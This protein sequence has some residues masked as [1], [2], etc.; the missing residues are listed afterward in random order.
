MMWCAENNLALST[1]KVKEIVLDFRRNAYPQPHS[2]NPGETAPEPSAQDLTCCLC[3]WFLVICNWW[4]IL[5][6]LMFF[7][8]LFKGGES[9]PRFHCTLFITTIELYLSLSGH[10]QVVP[11]PHM[12]LVLPKVF[13]G[14]CQATTDNLDCNEKLNQVELNRTCF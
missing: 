13:L 4:S 3:L 6:Y 5:F 8:I 14:F 12:S 2:E 1:A 7:T 9:N 11:L 10:R